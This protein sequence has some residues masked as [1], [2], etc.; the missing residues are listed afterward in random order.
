ML[1][2]ISLKLLDLTKNSYYVFFDI[3]LI[4][5]GC[6]ILFVKREMFFDK[7][8]VYVTASDENYFK[9]IFKSYK[10]INKFD[11]KQKIVFYDL[12]LNEIQKKALL[13][14]SNLT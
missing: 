7:S 2:N 5:F 11:P 13:E 12:G 14:F 6:I 1:K 9:K 10:G 8:I 4:I 3:C